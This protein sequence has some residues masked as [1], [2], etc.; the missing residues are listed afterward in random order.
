MLIW[1]N[2]LAL[3][4]R[5][6]FMYIRF[7]KANHRGKSWNQIQNA[8][9]KVRGAAVHIC[10]YTCI[11]WEYLDRLK[12]WSTCKGAPPFS[13]LIQIVNYNWKT[14]AWKENSMENVYLYIN[15]V[16]SKIGLTWRQFK[17]IK[18]SEKKSWNKNSVN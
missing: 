6:M 12:G 18:D 3:W 4:F 2:N 13:I 11:T 15:V 1:S 5:K 10:K 7:R 8:C 14:E 17:S 16:S 9:K